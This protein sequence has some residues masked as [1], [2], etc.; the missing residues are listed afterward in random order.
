MPEAVYFLS[1]GGS[2]AGYSFEMFL[3][4][5]INNLTIGFFVGSVIPIA[6][7]G[8]GAAKKLGI[9]SEDSLPFHLVRTLVIAVVMG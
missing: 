3:K 9:K 1:A 8:A 4:G 2:L 5:F 6:D 7:L